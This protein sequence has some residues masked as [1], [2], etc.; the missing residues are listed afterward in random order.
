MQKPKTRRWSFKRRMKKVE[1]KEVKSKEQKVDRNHSNYSETTRSNWSELLPHLPGA[2]INV[3]IKRGRYGI[4]TIVRGKIWAY[5]RH[6]D[7]IYIYR[8]WCATRDMSGKTEDSFWVMSEVEPLVVNVNA[9][10]EKFHNGKYHYYG[11]HASESIRLSITPGDDSTFD[12][13]RIVGY[14]FIM[15]Y[16]RMIAGI[17]EKSSEI[18]EPPEE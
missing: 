10:V 2:D 13:N 17:P 11:V 3:I 1:N 12:K 9:K 18:T 7:K 15:K 8:D 6:L 14:S 5:F 4:S 16:R